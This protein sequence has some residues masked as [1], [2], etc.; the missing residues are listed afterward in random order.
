MNN[1]S[2]VEVLV[3]S[4]DIFFLFLL[5]STWVP[6]ILENEQATTLRYGGGIKI[7]FTSVE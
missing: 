4:L 2:F 3:V 5:L 1:I 7:K 6:E